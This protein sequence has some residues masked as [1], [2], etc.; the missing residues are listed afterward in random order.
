MQSVRPAFGRMFV[1]LAMAFISMFSAEVR[2][3]TTARASR[4]PN[5]V[6]II[7]DDHHWGD[8]GFMGH[9]TIKTPNLDKLASQSL[10][11]KRGYVPSSLCCPSLATIITGLYPHQHKVTSNDPP[12][13]QGAK[14]NTPE[15]QKAFQA[16]RE[17]MNK[18]LEAVPT[19]PAMLKADGY[20]SLQ[21]GKWW[22]GH[23]SRGGFTHGMT[24][25]QRHGD[26][27]LDIGRKTMAPI[28]DFIAEAKKA[29][30]PFMVWYAPLLPHDPHTPPAEY[31][32]KYQDK[33]PSIH[34]AKYWA[35]VDWFD[36]TCGQLVD[37]IDQQG[38]G[39]N[40]IIVYVT[41]NGWIQNVDAPKYAPKSKQS[42][43]DGG[44]RT[45]IMIRWTGKIQPKMSDELAMSTDIVPTLLSAIGKKP[46]ADMQGINLLDEQAVKARKVI[47]GNCFTH[48]AVDLN[49]PEASLRWRWA[50]EGNTK[51]ILPA[52]Q[53]ETGG[54][55]LYDLAADPHETK[56][57]A[58]ADPKAVERLTKALDAWWP[59]KVE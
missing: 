37:H 17:V 28:F 59:G 42:P 35:M 12:G 56:N 45:P 1:C 3:D 57:L 20:L 10:T 6:L 43:Y 58:E 21:T 25:G 36:H 31:L 23:F 52:K 44:I 13:P 16:G 15:G 38:L 50:I 53:N 30:K 22:Q 9:P 8:Y 2:A 49:K 29:D 19:L 55:E 34:V 54:P 26:E 18:H 14:R 41:D 5:I 47:V 7:S 48:N 33:T 39:D 51:L 4:P 11:F 46:T 32:A 27:G 24:K 40:T